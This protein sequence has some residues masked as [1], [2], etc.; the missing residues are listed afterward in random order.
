MKAKHHCAT[1]HL[2][3]IDDQV[4][5]IMDLLDYDFG[6]ARCLGIHG[7]AAI[8]KTTLAKAL[9]DQLISNFDWYCFLQ[10]VRGS[11][12]RHG[13]VFLQ[14]KLLFDIL[15]ETKSMIDIDDIDDERPMDD[16]NDIDDG[17]MV[18]RKKL[19]GKKVLIVLDD[20]DHREQFEKLVGKINWLGTGSRVVITT[21]N[22]SIV[23]SGEKTILYE[24]REI[25]YNQALQLFINHAFKE[26]SPRDDYYDRLSRDI[27]STIGGL[28]LIIKVIGSFLHGKHETIWKDTLEKLRSIDNK[29]VR[30]MLKIS[31]DALNF[32]QKQIFLDIACLSFHEEEINAS[33]MWE[34]C[35]FFP[36]IEIEVLGSLSLIHIRENGGLWMHDMLKDLG[37]HIVHE[38]NLDPRKRSRLWISEEAMD[39]VK[40]R[41]NKGNIEALSL[42]GDP[43]LVIFTDEDFKRLP[44]LRFLDLDG[45]SFIGD[46]TD[47]FSKLRW[48]SWCYCPPDLLATNLFPQNLA[49]LRLS[50]FNNANDWA[51]WSQI[52]K[53][54]NL[55]VLQL[56]CLNIGKIELSGCLTLERLIIKECRELIQIDRSIGKLQQLNFLSI[57]GCHRLTDLPR[58]F[59]LLVK[60]RHLSL[61]HCS[62]L[63][64]LPNSIGELKSLI[65]LDLSYTSIEGLPYSVGYLV[66]LESLSLAGCT[67]IRELTHCIG[68][69]ESLIELDLSFTRIKEVP[70][71]IGLAKKLEVIRARCYWMVGEVSSEIGKLACLRILDLSETDIRLV[72]ET[73]VAL[74]LLEKLILKNCDKLQVLPSL[75]PSLTHLFVSSLS[76]QSIPDLSNLTTL[77]DL[78][79]SDNH[80]YLSMSS[81]SLIE[82]YNIECIGNLSKLVNLELCFP[83]IIVSATSLG[84]L[85]RLKKLS[86]SGLQHPE[87]LMQ[88]PKPAMQ[89]NLSSITSFP[90]L[91]NLRNL[92]SLKLC[93]S[94]DK[95]IHLG[96]LE[97]LRHLTVHQCPVLERIIFSTSGLEN[98]K[99][100]ELRD[101]P[102]LR[103]ICGLGALETLENLK[104]ELC[105]SIRRLNDLSRLQ[106]LM[107]LKIERCHSLDYWTNPSD[108]MIPD[109]CQIVIERCPQLGETPWW[110][111]FYKDYRDETLGQI[112]TGSDTSTSDRM[113]KVAK[114]ADDRQVASI[115]QGSG[116][117]DQLKQIMSLMNINNDKDERII[118]VIHGEGGTG[119]TTLAKLIYNQ[120][121]CDF[122]GCSF[123]ADI[124]EATQVVGGLQLLQTKL[125]S[126]VL[127][128]ELEDVAFVNRGMEFIRDLFCN[129]RVLIILD[130]VEN[131]FHVQKL[132]GDCFDCF[133]SGSRILVTTRNSV[134]LE[135]SPQIRTYHV[136][137][138]NKD[139]AFQLCRQYASMM[140]S[141]LRSN[142]NLSESALIVMAGRLLFIEVMAAV[143]N[144]KTQEEWNDLLGRQWSPFRQWDFQRILKEG[145]QTVDNKQKQIFLDIACLATGIDS[146]I[147]WYLWDDTSFL[148]SSEIVRPL[149]KIGENNQIWMHSMLRR[150]GREIV[151]WESLTDPGRRSRLFN[152]EIALDT[153]KR[154]KG[155]EKV[156]AL[157]LNFQ[158]HTSDKLTPEDFESMANLRF[159]QLDHADIAGDFTKNFLNLRWLRWRGCPQHLQVTNFHLGNLTIL[160]LSWSKVTKG[161]EGWDQIEMKNLRV[162]DLT[163]CADLL[164]TPKFS[165][166]KN[167]AILILERC[168]QLVKID[169]SISDL[170]CL[171][172]LNLKF[173]VELSRLPVEVGHL[174]ALKELLIDGTSVQEIPISIGHLKQ[175]ETLTASNCFSLSQL[176]RTVCHMTNIILLSLD[177]SRIAA[178]PDSIGELVRLKHLSLRDCRRLRE[179]PSSIGNI[180]RSLVELDMS[181]TR[182]SKFPDSIKNLQNLKVLRMDSCFFTEFP[183]DIGE[184]TSLKEIHASWCRSI[185]GAIPN[186][187]TKLHN[188]RILRLRHSRISSIPT[189]IHQLSKLQILDLLHCNMIK[190]LPR[191]P[192]SITVLY[193]EDELES[194]HLP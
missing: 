82:T 27:V 12:H 105:P 87:F 113:E 127:K 107:E 160:D 83:N 106:K 119:K 109:E 88:T 191:L 8:G 53:L 48:F 104:V 85:S 148:P 103:E 58:E 166:C 189:E 150:F 174:T 193:V 140:T 61:S 38:E 35:N 149:A 144:G 178:L 117:D 75:P 139:K 39:V 167:L 169:H 108:T 11:S 5:A 145:Y 176:P 18:I 188:L 68:K 55:K 22:K 131:A 170:K 130:N 41:E 146:R 96:G 94:R 157:C 177:G 72:P 70:S 194:S 179:L 90:D 111:M 7:P 59:G 47:L 52:K 183:P 65:E 17:M 168:S 133:A 156:E 184:L 97:K 77:V 63:L 165:G 112:T 71:S 153:I 155:T 44:N 76:L 129:M 50:K 122:D 190:E 187:I 164:V 162:L 79:L 99:E 2:V 147:A 31:F 33:Y 135:E 89:G 25:N 159:L 91:S 46:F 69:L 186:N 154:K 42:T 34:D 49:V 98:L 152:H 92:V 172:S 40:T 120:I 121:S 142:F 60:L 163:G 57:E 116:T 16:I 64:K 29:D 45:W 21:R 115:G 138:L 95:E 143:F 37:R 181:G 124:K 134:V 118:V 19:H 32:K 56:I 102:M 13:L 192:S 3:G 123:L 86:M 15:D 136:S 101:C 110:G 66:N 43:T 185:E 51:G 62:N 28:P 180:G 73:I 36:Q 9:F 128:R 30:Q 84:S 14:K 126:D 54:H 132:I 1:D 93:R 137:R 4:E 74:P 6:C 80:D 161:W 67:E 173:C 175:L 26:E 20:V 171:V 10:D 100:L 158:R 24:L 125:I 78:L 141:S 151:C 23:E 182:L 114:T 81:S